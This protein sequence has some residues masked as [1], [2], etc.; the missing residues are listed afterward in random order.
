MTCTHSAV[1]NG[2]LCIELNFVC[3]ALGIAEFK[4][5]SAWFVEEYAKNFKSLLPTQELGARTVAFVSHNCFAGRL[6]EQESRSSSRQTGCGS[7]S[8]LRTK[9]TIPSSATCSG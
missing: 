7:S 3:A 1:S 9:S 6:C 4:K 2:P 5:S 8:S